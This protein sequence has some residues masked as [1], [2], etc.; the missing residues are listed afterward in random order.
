LPVVLNGFG[1][2]QTWSPDF[3]KCL[4]TSLESRRK[5]RIKENKSYISDF[6]LKIFID[7]LGI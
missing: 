1:A 7:L 5:E 2:A 4:S 6:S 3:K